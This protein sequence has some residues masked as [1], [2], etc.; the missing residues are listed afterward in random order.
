MRRSAGRAGWWQQSGG[1]ASL[2]RL[3]LFSSYCPARINPTRP[4]LTWE[5][6]LTVRRPGREASWFSSNRARPPAPPHRTKRGLLCCNYCLLLFF[7]SLL[8]SISIYSS[9]QFPPILRFRSPTRLGR[10]RFPT[11]AR[12]MR[13][14]KEAWELGAGSSG[15]VAPSANRQ[16]G[17]G[18][19]TRPCIRCI[20]TNLRGQ[21]LG[22]DEE[23]SCF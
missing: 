21:R 11:G 14:K 6:G 10:E 3:E 13:K 12:T 18:R 23:E 17:N 16:I 15:E 5:F 22:E 4:D 8:L 19:G 1:A 2:E 9:S 20:S 7:Q